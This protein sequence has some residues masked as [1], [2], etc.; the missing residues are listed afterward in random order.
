MVKEMYKSTC[1]FCSFEKPPEKYPAMKLKQRWH[2]LLISLPDGILICPNCGRIFTN[3]EK[4]H[5]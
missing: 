4:R 5:S 1:P 3:I 2:V